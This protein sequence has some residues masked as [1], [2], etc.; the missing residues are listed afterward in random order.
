MTMIAD[1]IQNRASSQSWPRNSSISTATPVTIP[2]TIMAMRTCATSL[3]TAVRYSCG[4]GMTA[5]ADP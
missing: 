5:T 1:R 2:R 4:A 3:P